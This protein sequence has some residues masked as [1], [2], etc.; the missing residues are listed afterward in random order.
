MAFS[1]ENILG[2]NFTDYLLSTSPLNPWNAAREYTV[3]G[4][5]VC[6]V[7]TFTDGLINPFDNTNYLK[8]KLLKVVPQGTE[9]V[10][11]YQSTFAVIPTSETSFRVTYHVKGDA[12]VKLFNLNPSS[13]CSSSTKAA[14]TDTFKK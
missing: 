8:T 13:E 3:E 5:E 9:R 14:K 1:I 12:L 10:V 2:L 4:V 11:N 6:G 7:E